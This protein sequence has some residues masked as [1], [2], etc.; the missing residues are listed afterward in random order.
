MRLVGIGDT[1]PDLELK[2]WTG[3]AVRLS[4]AWQQ[5]PAVVFFLRH[6]GCPCTGQQGELIRQDLE[7]FRHA[8]AV[9]VVISL[10]PAERAVRLFAGLEKPPLVLIDPEQR[11]YQAY[12]LGRGGLWELAGPP[13][14]LTALKA[15]LQGRVGRPAGDVRQLAGVFLIDQ[16]GII[17]YVHRARHSADFPDHE[18]ILAHLAQLV[19]P[20][21]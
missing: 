7:R 12:G 6:L 15:L 9:V 10:G 20:G 4:G 13:V 2:D 17:R 16:H 1:A 21:G 18:A 19:R 3:G 8:G 5:G 11:A 14:W